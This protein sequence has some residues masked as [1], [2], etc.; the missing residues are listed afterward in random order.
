[1][2]KLRIYVDL[3][4]MV[5]EDSV[6]LSKEDTKMDSE[7]NVVVFYDKMPVFIYSDDGSAAGETDYLLADGIAINYDLNDYPEWKHVKW[8]VRIDW[9][10]LIHESDLKL[11]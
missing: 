2:D 1:M 9:S 4:E 7:G 5:T 3:N 11:L 10:S 6:L 8:C